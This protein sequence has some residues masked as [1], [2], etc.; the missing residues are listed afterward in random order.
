MKKLYKITP[1]KGH[2]ISDNSFYLEI[3]NGSNIN[4]KIRE[5]YENHK[6]N[7]DPKWPIVENLN[8][9]ISLVS[10]HCD[11]CGEIYNVDKNV[12]LNGFI[13]VCCEKGSEKIKFNDF[14]LF[15]DLME[16]IIS[17]NKNAQKIHE[18]LLISLELKNEKTRDLDECLDFCGLK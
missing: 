5:I 1:Q 7:F 9:E 12:F 4:L 3:E 6:I 13:P 2:G 18:E 15:K 11:C 17:I 16:E 10:I 14:P 8:T